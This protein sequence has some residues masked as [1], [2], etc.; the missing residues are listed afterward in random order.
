MHWHSKT[1]NY[2]ETNNF[3]YN[4]NLYITSMRH[5]ISTSK[6]GRK[7]SHRKALLRNLMTAL[8]LHEAIE[9][10]HTKAK[11]L[12]STF[13]EF[14]TKV[15]KQTAF[16]RVRAVKSVIYGDAAGKK[17]LEVVLPKYEARPYGIT[18]VVKL[19]RRKGDDALISKV[20]LV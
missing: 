2:L 9:T 12:E 6:L 20:E 13:A 10:T 16:N 3:Y 7:T 14:Y 19:Y 11:V 17:F 5:R 8:I 1:S 4:V 18:R 15:R